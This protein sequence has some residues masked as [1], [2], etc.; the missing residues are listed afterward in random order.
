MFIDNFPWEVLSFSEEKQPEI[1]R[2][3]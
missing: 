3:I 2:F 1:R